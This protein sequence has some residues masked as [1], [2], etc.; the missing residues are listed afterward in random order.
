[1][2]TRLEFDERLHRYTVGGR[3][4]LSVTQALEG[5]GYIDL[6]CIPEDV[7][8]RAAL[9]GTRVHE[10]A[11]LLMR[12]ELEW[13]SIDVAIAGYVLALDLFMRQTKFEPEPASVEKPLYCE[14][15]DYCG[16]PDVVGLYT[17]PRSY[18]PAL[19]SRVLLDWKSG[20]MPAA[21]YQLAA[22]AYALG[23]RH[24]AAVKLNREATYSVTW[25]KPETQREDFEVFLRALDVSRDFR[26]RREINPQL[27]EK[28]EI[29]G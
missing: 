4:V 23:V 3:E 24:R 16:T 9:R 11:A 20:M 22:Y 7:L 17:V 26:R 29:Y 14:E 13:S 18:G 8:R 5:A 28:E 25:Y 6:K 27:I 15:Y 19:K 1:M 12:N 10:A 2:N 21:R